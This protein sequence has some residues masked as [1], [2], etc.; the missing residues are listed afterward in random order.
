MAERRARAASSATASSGEVAGRNGSANSRSGACALKTSAAQSF[1]ARERRASGA[2]DPRS[3]SRTARPARR[4]P[5]RRCRRGPCPRGAASGRSARKPS[6]SR[7]ARESAVGI[8]AVARP[9]R[10]RDRRRIQSSRPPCSTTRGPTL[11]VLRGQPLLPQR[12]AAR[13]RDRGGRRRSRCAGRTPRAA[14]YTPRAAPGAGR[15]PEKTAP[16]PRIRRARTRRRAGLLASVSGVP[17][18]IG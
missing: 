11:A 9:V 2:R 5:R 10:A 7:S 3:G 15:R 16:R 8:G 13:G 14:H 12:R 4:R 18:R 1:Q 6:S 17:G